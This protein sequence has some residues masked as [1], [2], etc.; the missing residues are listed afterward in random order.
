M[1]LAWIATDPDTHVV[2]RMETQS[3]SNGFMSRLEHLL[4]TG[5][6]CAEVRHLEGAF[7]VLT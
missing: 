1:D 3:D 7:P 6:G 2:D 4:G 5:N